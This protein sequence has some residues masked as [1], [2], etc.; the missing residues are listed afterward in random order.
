[1]TI[2]FGESHIYCCSMNSEEQCGQSDSFR[3]V[4]PL[5]FAEES[6]T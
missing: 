6:N 3:R 2:S 4:S 5:Y 1:M